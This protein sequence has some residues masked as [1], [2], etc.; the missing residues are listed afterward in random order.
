[1]KRTYILPLAAAGLWGILLLSGIDSMEDVRAQQAP[2]Y[3]SSGQVDFYV[4]FPAAVVALI[5]VTWIVGALYHP[6]RKP[7]GILIIITL[8]LAPIYFAVSGGGV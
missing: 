1:M 5:V 6:A 4:R 8:I 3:P 7:A 2:G